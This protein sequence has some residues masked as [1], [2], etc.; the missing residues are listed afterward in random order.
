MDE[1][2]NYNIDTWEQDSYQTGST[3]PPKNRGGLIAGLC[4]AVILLL[5]VISALGVMNIRMFQKLQGKGQNSMSFLEGS[6]VADNSQSGNNLKPS[7][8]ADSDITIELKPAPDGMQNIPQQGGLSY[9]QIYDKNIPSVVSVLCQ[10]PSG[11]GTGT[12][13][14]L[15]EQG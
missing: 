4:V 13:V 10:M 2:N 8:P 12:G 6:S 7:V 15:S 3:N 5:G 9:Q 14:I 1:Y 11:S